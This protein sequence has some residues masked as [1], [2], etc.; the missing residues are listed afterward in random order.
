VA[1]VPYLAM[2]LFGAQHRTFWR[3]GAALSDAV[4]E[5]LTMKMRIIIIC[6]NDHPRRLRR[7]LQL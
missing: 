1:G 5:I 7:T 2:P 6:G 3:A 4:Q